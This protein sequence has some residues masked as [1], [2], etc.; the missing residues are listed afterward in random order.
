MNNILTVTHKASD[1][2]KK[3]IESAPYGTIGVVVGLDKSGCNGYSYKLDFIK[4]PAAEPVNPFEL[5]SLIKSFFEKETGFNLENRN[6]Y[7]N[8]KIYCLECETIN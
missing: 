7:N 3:L 5:P 4:P 2:L 8:I 6:M 1:Q